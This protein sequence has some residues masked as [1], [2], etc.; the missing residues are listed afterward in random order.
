M[1]NEPSTEQMNVWASTK[2]ESCGGHG[3]GHFEDCKREPS[4]I[5]SMTDDLE[6]VCGDM[7]SQH[8]D[9]QNQCCIPDCGCKEYESKPESHPAHS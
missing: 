9:A 6:C 8:I 5:P 7:Q 1:K 2:C 3:G 4:G